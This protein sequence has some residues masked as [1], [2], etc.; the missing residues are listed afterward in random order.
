M[1]D[2]RKVVGHKTFGDGAGGFR[3]EPLYADEAEELWRHAEEKDAYR[4]QLMPTE[5][6]A[7]ALF[8]DAWQRLKDFGWR[9]AVY[10]PKDGTHFDAIEPGSTGIHDCAYEGEWPKGSWWAYW[11]GDCG[12]SRPALFRPKG[13]MK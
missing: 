2:E 7:I 9:E 4:R 12:P 10:C 5:Q 3:H 6:D 13:D 11:D 8:F 1:A